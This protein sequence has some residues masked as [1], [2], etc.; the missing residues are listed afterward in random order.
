MNLGVGCEI[1]PV[2][3]RDVTPSS[4]DLWFAHGREDAGSLH[5]YAAG[6]LP[7]SED[8]VVV[9]ALDD[10]VGSRA[11]VSAESGVL[12][13]DL[14]CGPTVPPDMFLFF[15]GPENEGRLVLPPVTA[16]PLSPP[17]R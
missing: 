16:V 7:D 12:S 1:V 9:F 17:P 8:Y 2:L 5:L 10:G 3:F 4:L 15:Y 6:R 14:G 13:V 11:I